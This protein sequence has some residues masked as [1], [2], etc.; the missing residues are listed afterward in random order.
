M[1]RLVL[2]FSAWTL[3]S[4]TPAA[5]QDPEDVREKEGRAA[6]ARADYAKALEIFSVLFA[7]KAEPV[8]LRNI[9]R[10]Y[11]KLGKPQQSI[12]SFREYLRREKGLTAEERAE[13]DGFIKEMEDLRAA[14][15]ARAAASPVGAPPVL[16]PPAVNL[17][18]SP[19][20]P[21]APALVVAESPP[22]PSAHVTGERPLY[23]KW[24]FWAGVGAVLLTG[25]VTAIALS[26]GRSSIVPPC[27]GV[28]PREAAGGL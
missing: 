26:S 8:Y 14:E 24:W 11:Q 16:T 10:C 17:A 22:P 9:G 23:K 5:A 25:T 20:P 19:P 13:I 6:F 28:C 3:L 2:V 18:P 4:P 27:P 15:A 21:V 7:D 12:D 1:N